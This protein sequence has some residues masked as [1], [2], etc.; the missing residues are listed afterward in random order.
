[1]ETCFLKK[2]SQK[3]FLCSFQNDFR[4]SLASQIK[5]E[6]GLLDRVSRMEYQE[7]NTKRTKPTV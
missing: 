3:M 7:K 4:F 2:R 6:A 1:M 5:Q